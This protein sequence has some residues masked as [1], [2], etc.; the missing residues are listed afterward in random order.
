MHLIETVFPYLNERLNH[1]QT[2]KWK[3]LTALII[4]DEGEKDAS[5]TVRRLIAQPCMHIAWSLL[6]FYD[7]LS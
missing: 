7:Y 4:E 6:R 5:E 1:I 3:E 2:S